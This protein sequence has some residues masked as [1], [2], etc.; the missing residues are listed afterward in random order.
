TACPEVPVEVLDPRHTWSD[1]QAYDAA[2]A[3]LAGMFHENFHKYGRNLPPA[4]AA[5]GPQP[6]LAPVAQSA[7]R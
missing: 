5:S 4:V 3:R 6:D 1:K 2:A 7:S